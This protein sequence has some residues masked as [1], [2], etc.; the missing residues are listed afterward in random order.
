MEKAWDV[1]RKRRFTGIHMTIR[2]VDCEGFD[3]D[4]MIRRFKAMHIDMFTF[5]TGGYVTTYPSELEYQRISPYLSA[6]RDLAGEIVN[7]ANEAGIIPLAMIDLSIL[8]LKAARLHPDWAKQ[9][10]NGNFEYLN[11]DNVNACLIGGWQKEYSVKIVKEIIK[12]FPGIAGI[13]FGGGSYGFGKSICHCPNCKKAFLEYSG[14]ELPDTIVP[15]SDIW[16]EYMQWRYVE[17]AKRVRELESMVKNENPDLLVMGNSVCFGNPDWTLRSSLNQE[18]LVCFQDLVQIEAQDHLDQRKDMNGAYF[19]PLLF[20]S[21]ETIYMSSITDKP[22]II[23]SPYFMAWPWRR[24]AMQY[25]EQKCWIYQAVAN[26]ANPMI[27]LSGGP[28][29]V[30]EDQRGFA[31]IEEV[32]GFYKD[33]IGFF[34]DDSSMARIA[35]VYSQATLMHYQDNAKDDYVSC[36]RGFEKIFGDLHIPYD[37]VPVIKVESYKDK[38]DILIYANTACV[39][40]EDVE[41]LKSFVSA[42]GTVICTGDFLRYDDSGKECASFRLANEMGIDSMEWD[43][44]MT[45]KD[46]SPYQTYA[47]VPENDPFVLRNN[48]SS[49]Y[50]L[51]FNAVGFDVK[52]ART[53]LQRTATF[54][55]F[56]EGLSYAVPEEWAVRKP[57]AICKDY[58]KG[59]FIY[60]G[61]P[62]GKEYFLD[63]ITDMRDIIEK[64]ISV[65]P[66]YKERISV[67]APV[68]VMSFFRKQ[69]GR[70]N[71]HL[72]NF[73]SSGRFLSEV[74][75]VHNIRIEFPSSVSVR[76]V[77]LVRSGIDIP[78]SSDNTVTIPKLCD[79][80]LVSAEIG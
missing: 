44:P 38:Y 54:R 53:I 72:V 29:L 59:E 43:I 30:H 12:R 68:S 11:E 25:A 6:G 32:F 19:Q 27:N 63:G 62:L 8:P 23:V 52:T 33:N 18:E 80:E 45:V 21:E 78:V 77:H 3:V 74:V 60:F 17:T 56:P 1:L 4:D 16:N 5:F 41:S 51:D 42:G 57:L 66:A 22:V 47:C 37:I 65:Y 79:F 46:N 34:Q 26:G 24:T 7:K 9:D 49:L 36:I 55:V 14:R 67:V 64:T 70:I 71:I 2:D 13:K 58:G 69:T 20:P 15:R 39:S 76:N 50:P 40:D 35:I 28:P 73:S 48:S 10:C 61:W 75:P 31:A